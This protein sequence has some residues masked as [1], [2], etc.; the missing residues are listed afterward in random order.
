MERGSRYVWEFNRTT[1][2]WFGTVALTLPAAT[3]SVTVTAICTESPLN[4]PVR[5]TLF[6]YSGATP[7]TSALYIDLASPARHHG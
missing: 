5:A 7:N 3:H 2:D 1:S 6:T 4:E